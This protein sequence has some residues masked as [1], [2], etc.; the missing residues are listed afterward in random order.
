L[1][2]AWGYKK[3]EAK[4]GGGVKKRGAE[5]GGC[6]TNRKKGKEV[7]PRKNNTLGKRGKTQSKQPRE[8]KEA[9]KRGAAPQFT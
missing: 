1:S 7:K 6:S 8:K 9:K 5:G 2:V 3:K 4:T